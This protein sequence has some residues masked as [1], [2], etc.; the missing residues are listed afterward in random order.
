MELK[1][2][3]ILA[4]IVALVII[5]GCVK[6]VTVGEHENTTVA[7]NATS[8]VNTSMNKTVASNASIKTNTTPKTTSTTTGNTTDMVVLSNDTEAEPEP[9]TTTPVEPAKPQ[10]RIDAT[11][12]STTSRVVSTFDGKTEEFTVPDVDHDAIVFDIAQHLGRGAKE[13]RPFIYI[14]GG[15]YLKPAELKKALETVAVKEATTFNISSVP[16]TKTKEDG[17]LRGV[18]CDLD[19]GYLRIDL[20]NDGEDDVPIYKSRDVAPKVK[21]ALVISL[22]RRPLENMNCGNT[23]FVL[24]AGLKMTCIKGQSTFISSG[25][26]NAFQTNGSYDLS[27]PDVVWANRPGYK[28]VIEFHCG[29]PEADQVEGDTNQ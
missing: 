19:N 8:T 12:Q 17:F 18:G 7:K 15:A 28:E 11:T 20:A 9:D 23:S 21:N 10:N 22:N 16:I 13:V 27:Q 5:C 14:N 4:G 29:T 26:H 24:Q 25:S 2:L 6:P 3:S 1:Q